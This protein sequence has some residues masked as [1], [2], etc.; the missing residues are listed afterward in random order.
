VSNAIVRSWVE[1]PKFANVPTFL[2][3]L[4]WQLGINIEIEVEKGWFRETVRFKVEGEETKV[5][6]FFSV[7]NQ[8]AEEYQAV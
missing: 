2:K 4:A 8:A 3:N 5:K 1:A 7:F 6:K